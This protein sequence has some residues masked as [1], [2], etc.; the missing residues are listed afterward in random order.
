MYPH[1]EILIILLTELSNCPERHNNDTFCL[2]FSNLPCLFL[3]LDQKYNESPQKIDFF[4]KKGTLSLGISTLK[5]FKNMI[6]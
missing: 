1:L 6:I 5:Q 3:I 4:V 2:S